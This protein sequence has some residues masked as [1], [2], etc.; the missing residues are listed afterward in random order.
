MQKIV[1]FLWFDTEAEEAAQFYISLFKHSEMVET[2]YYSEG[3]PRPA[4]SVLVVNFDL[5]GQRF[6]AINAGPQFTPNPAISFF[7]TLEAEAEV[8]ALWESL[9][10]GGAVLMPLQSYDWSEKY[11]WLSDR[12]GVS[13]QLSLGKRGEVG[14]AIV[15]S[16]LF[17]GEQFGRAEEGITFYTDLFEDSSLTHL[18]HADAE[19]TSVQHAQFVLAGQTFMAMDSGLEHNFSFDEAVSL[20]V[21]CGTQGEVDHFWNA[22]SAQSDAEQCGWLRDKFGISW[23]IVPTVLSELM[24][25]SDPQKARRVTEALMAMKKLEIAGLQQ[26]YDAA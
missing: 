6:A 1:P 23:Q 8:D 5:E 15:P 26:A 9:S 11:G 18:R 16:L 19:Q 7:V 22:L 17:V 21:N 20:L 2:S 4:G 13:W 14:Q 12:Y 10:E 3:A 25:D 24:Q